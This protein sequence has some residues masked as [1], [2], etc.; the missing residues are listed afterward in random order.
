MATNH[1]GTIRGPEP[2]F[3]GAVYRATRNATGRHWEVDHF[4]EGFGWRLWPMGDDWGTGGGVR[5]LWKSTDDL[6]DRKRWRMVGVTARAPR[7]SG[8]ES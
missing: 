3:V 6:R 4:R 8:G 2:P 7:L 5:A 1:N